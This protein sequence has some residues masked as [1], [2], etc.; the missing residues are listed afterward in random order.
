MELLATI[1]ISV[2]IIIGVIAIFFLLIFSIPQLPNAIDRIEDMYYES[3]FIGLPKSEMLQRFENHTAYVTFVEKYPEPSINFEYHNG[4]SGNMELDVM[5]FENYNELRLNISYNHHNEY[6]RIHVVCHNQL[7]DQHID[8]DHEL[9]TQYLIN[10]NC[11]GD[12][13]ISGSSPLV[14][15]NGN[16][17]PVPEPQHYE[18][19]SK[20]CGPDARY[21]EGVCLVNNEVILD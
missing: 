15:E 13:P 4:E 11:L 3:E 14:D 8:F 18:I 6:F 9:A 12:G 20:M 16:P 17:V 10:A 7:I 21:H 19:P 5:N 1:G 2:G